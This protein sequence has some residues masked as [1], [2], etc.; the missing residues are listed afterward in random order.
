MARLHKKATEKSTAEIIGR[1]IKQILKEKNLTQIA[2]GE[3]AGIPRSTMSDYINGKTMMQTQT[4]K[5]IAASLEVPVERIDHS[6]GEGTLVDRLG[7]IFTVIAKGEHLIG[8]RIQEGDSLVIRRQRYCNE[9]DIL[10]VNLNGELT[11]KKATHKKDPQVALCSINSEENPILIDERYQY[12]VI[13]G[14]LLR[15]IIEID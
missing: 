8:G 11:L 15:I 9:G 7:E 4:L 10:L 14:K 12:M 5:E 3:L 6:F 2:L 13:E 1:N